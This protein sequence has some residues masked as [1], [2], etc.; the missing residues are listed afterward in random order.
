MGTLDEMKHIMPK[1]VVHLRGHWNKVVPLMKPFMKP[2]IL[3]NM[4]NGIKF[5]SYT[6]WSIDDTWN[7]HFLCCVNNHHIGNKNLILESCKNQLA[8]KFLM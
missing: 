4:S 8:I 6:C 1:G 5:C 7:H 3:T 2:F